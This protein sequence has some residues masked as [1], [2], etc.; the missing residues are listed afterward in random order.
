MIAGAL[1]LVTGSKLGRLAAMALL[2]LFLV[3]IIVRSLMGA[4][5]SKE[6]GKIA[7]ARVVAIRRKLE[8]DHEIRTMDRAGRRAEF[9]R[10]LRNGSGAG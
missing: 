2:G 4:G 10:W 5:A 6:R 8:V 1:A 3:M 9:D 7:A